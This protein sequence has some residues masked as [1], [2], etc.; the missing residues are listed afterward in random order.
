MR[1]TSAS[2][3][4]SPASAIAR[5]PSALTSAVVSSTRSRERAAQI[6]A[7]PSPANIRLITRPTPLLAPVMSATFPVSCPISLSRTRPVGNASLKGANHLVE[8]DRRAD[9]AHFLL[10]AG[11]DPVVL[12]IRQAHVRGERAAHHRRRGGAVVVDTGRH[13]VADEEIRVA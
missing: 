8:R 7:A 6:T 12:V 13:H 3:A 9:R 4:A 11:L 2:T 10:V 5:P 1:S